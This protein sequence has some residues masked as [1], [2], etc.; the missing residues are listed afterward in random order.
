VADNSLSARPLLLDATTPGL[1]PPEETKLH[2]IHGQPEAFAP[3][4]EENPTPRRAGWW[5]RKKTG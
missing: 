2:P 1:D 5:N 3:P 4:A